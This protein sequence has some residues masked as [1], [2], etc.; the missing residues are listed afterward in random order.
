[1]RH[2]YKHRIDPASLQVVTVA[3]TCTQAELGILGKNRK[4]TLNYL[5]LQ[6][7]D[8]Q[9]RDRA[10]EE[11]DFIRKVQDLDKSKLVLGVSVKLTDARTINYNTYGFGIWERMD[12]DILIVPAEF[13][14]LVKNS[15]ISVLNP[16][17]EPFN[18]SP[19]YRIS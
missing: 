3:P 8:S 10:L 4:G 5:Y 19:P 9:D 14:D 7:A 13:Y 17:R 2:E 16:P 12:G 11:V 18:S 6:D 1:M 15:E